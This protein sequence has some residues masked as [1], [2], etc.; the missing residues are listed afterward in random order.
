[1]L[2]NKKIIIVILFIFLILGGCTKEEE[3]NAK[4]DIKN[5]EKENVKEETM[6]KEIKLQVNNVTYDILLEN[7]S[8]TEALISKLQDG[9]ITIS[10]SDYG[11]FEK[12]GDLGFDLPRNDTTITTK[13]GDLILY[14]GN[15]ITLYYATN[16][17]NFTKLGTIKNVDE[18]NLKETLGPNDVTL[19]L[20]LN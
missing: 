20:S 15:K 6:N 17:W 2:N 5:E 16:N 10:A 4:K 13:P 14:E 11:N 7:N 3:L 1:M 9:P 8:S 12:V 19:V 18:E